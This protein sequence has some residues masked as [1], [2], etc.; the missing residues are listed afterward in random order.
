MY[1]KELPNLFVRIHLEAALARP[2][3]SATPNVAFASF[4]HVVTIAFNECY[5]V[6]SAVSYKGRCGGK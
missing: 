1:V 2:P 4:V 5:V 3:S 6:A